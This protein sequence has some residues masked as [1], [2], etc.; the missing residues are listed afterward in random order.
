MK[1]EGF[2]VVAAVTQRTTHS[3]FSASNL[4]D[5]SRSS[6]FGHRHTGTHEVSQSLMTWPVRLADDML[7][8]FFES[9][10]AH[11]PVFRRDYSTVNRWRPSIQPVLKPLLH[12]FYMLLVP[13]IRDGPL[14]E[15]MRIHEVLYGNAKL[16]ASH[17]LHFLAFLQL[18]SA[19]FH[20]CKSQQFSSQSLTNW[21]HSSVA[22]SS[23]EPWHRE[24]ESHALIEAH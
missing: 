18:T 21:S 16:D 8:K 4:H 15:V 9:I 20:S 13:S 3:P 2:L 1:F 23:S 17:F 12:C 24:I 11:G 5:S 7:M 14:R 22:I 10:L 19:V 6:V